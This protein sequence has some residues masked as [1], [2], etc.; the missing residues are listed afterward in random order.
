M[1]I[2][3][4]FFRASLCASLALTLACTPPINRSDNGPTPAEILGNPDYQAMSYGGYRGKT[5]DE[6]PTVEQLVDDI[7]ILN[8]MGIKLLRT[9][10]TSQFPQAERLLEA[11]RREKQADPSFEMY[12][13]LGAWIEAKNSWAE[14]VWDADNDTW[15][16]GTGPDHTQGNLQNNSQEINTAIRLANEYPDIVKAIAVGNEAMV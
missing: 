3:S 1:G 8:A 16:E 14:A 4:S 12:V 11:I 6:G 13:M 7:R 9:Y 2:A 5:R 10:N 15:I